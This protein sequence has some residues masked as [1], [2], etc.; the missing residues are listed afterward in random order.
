MVIDQ[1]TQGSCQ[2][3]AA[4]KMTKD[5]LYIT[6]TQPQKC[7]YRVKGELEMDA[8]LRNSTGKNVSGFYRNG[9]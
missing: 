1:S 2:D 3:N 6:R 8:S 9:M 5:P 7:L 4:C